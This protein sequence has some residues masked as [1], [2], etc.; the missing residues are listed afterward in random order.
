[1][2]TGLFRSCL[3]RF[4]TFDAVRLKN[5]IFI[6]IAIF[7][8]PFGWD[9]NVVSVLRA[10]KL[11]FISLL[12]QSSDRAQLKIRLIG[13]QSQKTAARVSTPVTELGR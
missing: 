3:T 6:A 12:C 10:D 2:V 8:R 11:R 5:I 13:A 9:Q 7:S 1:M 4:P